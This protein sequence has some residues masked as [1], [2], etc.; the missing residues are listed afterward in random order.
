MIRR[1]LAAMTLMVVAVLAVAAPAQAQYPPGTCGFVLDPPVIALG[2][3][4]HITGGGFEPNSTVT[5]EIN[6]QFLGSVVV[7]DDIDGP[8]DAVFTVPAGLP[9]G[10]YIITTACDGNSFAQSVVVGNPSLLCG[11]DIFFSGQ[12][13][14]LRLPSFEVNTPITVTLNPGGSPL[15]SGPVTGNPMTVDV[16]MP[17]GL[18]AG[19]YTIEAV[20]TGIDGQPKTLICAVQ[21]QVTNL[22]VTG[23]DATMTLVRVGVALLTVGGLLFVVSRKRSLA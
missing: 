5:F 3:E 10:E 11:I 13:A 23:S 17:T 20:G 6:G 22:P 8:I 12:T 2:G 7:P 16:M 21:A 14:S 19:E 18:T 9:D 4:V 1:L 15:Y